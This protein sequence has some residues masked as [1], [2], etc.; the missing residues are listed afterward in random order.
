MGEKKTVTASGS[1]IST[2][3]LVVF[4]VLKC[5]GLI[6]WSWWWVLAP[7][8]I[9]AILVFIYLVVVFTIAIIQ[10]NKERIFK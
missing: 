3:L 2:I 6:N 7:L 9:P 5:T 10:E 8:W 1:G 4:I